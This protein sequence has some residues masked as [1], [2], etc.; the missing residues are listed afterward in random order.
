MSQD[1]PQ[2]TSPDAGDTQETRPAGEGVQGQ[3]SQEEEVARAAEVTQAADE[4]RTGKRFSI[5]RTGVLLVFFLALTLVVL[6]M[7]TPEGEAFW[8]KLLYFRGEQ[9]AAAALKEAG[10]LV[11]SEPPDKRV[12]NVDFLGKDV[13]D[14]TLGRLSKLYRLA[15]LNLAE[16]NITDQQLRHVSGL[17]ELS[18]LVLGGTAVTDAG[19]VHLG[20]LDNVE[21]LHVP[22][23]KVSDK[24]LK[25]LARIPKLKILDLSGTEIT[26]EG[27]KQVVGAGQIR[28]LLMSRT[29]ITDEGL[30]HLEQMKDLGRLTIDGTNVTSEGLKRLEEAVPGISI[31][32]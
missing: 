8:K 14:A 17:S 9:D 13:D 16:T 31:D 23:T 6:A 28:W 30:K 15:N 25:H 1:E 32:R 24:G 7:F 10:E 26:D 29:E 11:I 3:I 27:L 2:E 5:L 20:K 22:N 21:A 19:M 12:T 18:S 4:P